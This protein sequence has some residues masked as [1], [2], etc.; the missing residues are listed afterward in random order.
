MP[1]YVCT[2]IAGQ[3]SPAHKADIAAA[4]TRI[5]HEV[6]GAPAH[7]AQ[8]VF[9]EA[10]SGD[11]FIGGAPLRHQHLFVH[12]HI[13]DGRSAVDKS[14]LIGELTRVLPGLAGIAHTG[15]WIYLAELPARQMVEFGH[16][17]PAAGDEAAWSQSLPAEDRAFMESLCG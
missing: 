2:A 6:T 1:T 12:G 17:L 3:L 8:V 9:R 7:F 16:V 4:I 5:H 15:I 13:R 11:I 14:A 10:V